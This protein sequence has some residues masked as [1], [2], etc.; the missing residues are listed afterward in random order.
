MGKKEDL[1]VMC[2]DSS[3]VEF[4]MEI[5]RR[6]TGNEHGILSGKEHL[7]T[8]EELDWFLA[9][10]G[11]YNEATKKILIRNRKRLLNVK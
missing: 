4:E 2:E 6:I 9:R 11:Y 8:I 3:D 5:R 10:P 7:F 1:Q